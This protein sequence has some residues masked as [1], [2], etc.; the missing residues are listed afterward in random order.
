MVFAVEWE[1]PIFYLN[2]GALLLLAITARRVF[3]SGAKGWA[4]MW[5]ILLLGVA[6]H[7]VGDLTGLSEDT[8]HLLIH[9]TLLLALVP[10]TIGIMKGALD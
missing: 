7:F 3:A 5:G 9:A 4:W 10:A 1:N 2:A 8:D 6:V